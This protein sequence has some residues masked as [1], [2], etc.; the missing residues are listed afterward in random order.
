ML[1]TTTSGARRDATPQEA[2]LLPDAML[3][4]QLTLWLGLVLLV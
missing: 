4:V 3:L 1:R 2:V